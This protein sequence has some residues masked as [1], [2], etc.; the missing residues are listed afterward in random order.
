[1]ICWNMAP[2]PLMMAKSAAED[3]CCYYWQQHYQ[4]EL[5]LHYPASMHTN[6]GANPQQVPRLEDA[7][8]VTF[9]REVIGSKSVS[10]QAHVH[11]CGSIRQTTWGTAPIDELKGGIGFGIKTAGDIAVSAAMGKVIEQWMRAQTGSSATGAV[12]ESSRSRHTQQER[13]D[14]KV[15]PPPAVA[16]S[17]S[18]ALP[19]NSFINLAP[20]RQTHPTA[21]TLRSHNDRLLGG[22]GM[23]AGSRRGQNC[24]RLSESSIPHHPYIMRSFLP[25][26]FP[27]ITTAAGPAIPHIFVADELQKQPAVVADDGHD[28]GAVVS[29]QNDAGSLSRRIAKVVHCRMK[30]PAKRRSLLTIRPIEVGASSSENPS[31]SASSHVAHLAAGGPPSPWPRNADDAAYQDTEQQPS[32]FK[33]LVVDDDLI[34]TKD[35][36]PCFGAARLRRD[37]GRGRLRS[38][39]AVR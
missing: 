31:T 26:E 37:Y 35:D 9:L 39:Q 23:P 34:N 21:T 16:S 8:S 3:Y 22:I 2:P 19:E 7:A 5:Q 24:P 12:D 36:A 20:R 32:K 6:K 15:L 33:V 29:N 28:E 27:R 30:D 4:P 14:E 18:S 13:K 38:P 10:V 25:Q 11:Y 17:S 1:M